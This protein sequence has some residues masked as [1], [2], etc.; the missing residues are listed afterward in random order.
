MLFILQSHPIQEKE[1]ICF[2]ADSTISVYLMMSTFFIVLLHS[3]Y[4]EAESGLNSGFK[5]SKGPL[6]KKILNSFLDIKGKIV[7]SRIRG[8]LFCLSLENNALCS[9]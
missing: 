5:R 3:A 9:L 8:P 7:D 2:S 1:I 6:K 4:L